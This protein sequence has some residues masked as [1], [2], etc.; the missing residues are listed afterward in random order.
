MESEDD[1][2]LHSLHITWCFFF[3]SR[4]FKDFLFLI[5]LEELLFSL[6]LSETQWIFATTHQGFLKNSET[7]ISLIISF[8]INLTLLVHL[9]FMKLSY[10]Y[11][12]SWIIPPHLLFHKL[13]HPF[14][15][16]TCSKS[17]GNKGIG[18][19]FLR[20]TSLVLKSDHPTFRFAETLLKIRVFILY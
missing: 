15:F 7:K 16:F 8:K 2:I 18:P 11:K 14:Y 20:V 19:L 9:F 13:F 4:S 3:L 1:L 12:I 5:F 17:V 10:T 6:I